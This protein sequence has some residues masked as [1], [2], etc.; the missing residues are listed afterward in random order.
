MTR[1]VDETH[2]DTPTRSGKGL[3]VTLLALV[4]TVVLIT[5][6]WLGTQNGRNH[7]PAPAATGDITPT[8]TATP[9]TTESPPLV[10]TV[11]EELIP[12]LYRGTAT[13]STGNA[14]EVYGVKVGWD[15]T[16]DGAVGAA[17]SV[18]GA[19][20]CLAGVVESTAAELFPHLYTGQSL[21]DILHDPAWVGYRQVI[22]DASRLSD[23]G[24]VMDANNPTLPSTEERFYGGAIP[25]YGVYK[26]TNIENDTDG[27]PLRVEVWTF[28]PRYS[29]TGTDTNMD[30][31]VR[32]FELIRDVMVWVDNDWKSED[33]GIEASTDVRVTNPGWEF[34]MSQVGE[35]WA[36]PADGTQDPIPGAVL[37]Q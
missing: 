13:V 4:M 1:I 14:R 2:P 15:R 24:V 17:M 5:V 27:Q 18:A 7:T 34:I 9:T 23:D 36:V 30:G 11:T 26:I 29:G 28:L 32:S 19:D 22:R 31:V 20:R 35:G 37:T 3:K 6:Y 12:G 8:E 25:E 21:E 10:V 16:V 33:G